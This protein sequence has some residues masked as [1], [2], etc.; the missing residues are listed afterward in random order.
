MT[1]VTLNNG[2]I[3]I[4]D[5]CFGSCESLTNLVLPN[6]VTHIGSNCFFFSGLNNITLSENLK[7]LSDECFCWCDLRSIVLPPSI[8]SIG[9]YCFAF[10]G[11]LKNITLSPNIVSL[12]DGCF[13]MCLSLTDIVMPD[14]ITSFGRFC[15][16]GC[17]SLSELILPEKLSTIK[18]SCFYSCDNLKNIYCYSSEVPKIN[19]EGSEMPFSQATLH[20]LPG[21]EDVYLNAEWWRNFFE[22][23]GDAVVDGI[24]NGL[25][26]K[27]KVS[28]RGRRLSV[29]GISAKEK[30]TVADAN[31]IILY[32][33]VNSVV[34]LPNIGAYIIKVK[35]ITHKI[36]VE[37]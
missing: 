26:E 5:L 21:K 4:G 12:N 29:S 2:L 24:N 35:G 14:N 22:I 18:D 6:S 3:S 16:A 36:F 19:D 34:E 30:I 15:F 8:T 31:G 25:K 27:V 28:V 20:V 1:D 32:Q 23:K 7:S 13:A 37:L 10:S 9:K 17:S 11:N 33:G